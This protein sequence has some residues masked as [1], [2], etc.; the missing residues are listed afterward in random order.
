MQS[1]Q[2]NV[3]S[4]L[5]LDGRAYVVTGA[6]SGI[7]AAV[8]VRLSS[9]GAH[10]V[11]VDRDVVRASE[12]VHANSLENCTVV[13][14]DVSDKQETANY[15]ARAADVAGQIDGI[16]LNAGYY[17]PVGSLAD[18]DLASYELHMATNARGVFL[19]IRAA[20]RQF[21]RQGC[22]GSIL[23]TASTAGLSG[24]QGA[25]S[26]CAAKHA[27]VGLVRAAALDHA[28]EGIR[29]NAIC[30]G[31]VDT[32]MLRSALGVES[33]VTLSTAASQLASRIPLG[34]IGAAAELARAAAWLLGPESSYVT[35]TTL[36]VDGGLTAGRFVPP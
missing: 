18:T 25:A 28:H 6:G 5:R 14:A 19:G 8:A 4:D 7:G 15:I 3:G 17:S 21:R 26:Y 16:H 34:R 31:E 22:G 29:V 10:V 24:S 33:D 30:P 23:V 1:S 9:N 27:A 12:V 11:L 32:S 36:T 2:N 13:K 35:G 20:V